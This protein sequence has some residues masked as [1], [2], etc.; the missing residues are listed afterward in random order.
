MSNYETGQND[1]AIR[2]L[3]T[4]VL[5]GFLSRAQFGVLA[6]HALRGEEKRFFQEKIGEYATRIA[7]M[8][9]TYEQDGKGDQAIV[10]LHYFQGGMDAWITEKDADP[11]GE[12]QVQAF[13][14]VNMGWG[15]EYGYVSIK[16]L[17]EN[18]FE[19]DLHWTPKTVAEAKVGV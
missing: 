17:C 4:T 13:G 19:L 9:K 14:I 3:L 7:N 16:E 5:K 8:P 18:G 10:Y 1:I 12:G 2:H 6:N 11:D 15:A